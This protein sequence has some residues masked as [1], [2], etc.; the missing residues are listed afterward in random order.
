MFIGR[1]DDAIAIIERSMMIDPLCSI[2]LYFASRLYMFAGELEE[3]VALRQRFIS[4]HGQGHFQYGL[5][6]LL[7]GKPA[8]AATVFRDFEELMAERG[9]ADRGEARVGLAMAFHDLGRA[10]ESDE[11]L[12]AYIDDFGEQN[13]RDVAKIYAWRGEKD[14]AFEWLSRADETGS[15]GDRSFIVDPVFTNLHDDPRWTAMLEARGF[16]E[17]QLAALVFPVELFTEYR[18]E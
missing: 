3:A 18:G 6:K 7:Q 9:G 14:L 11:L 10:G 4:L 16:S 5:M 1:K 8:E 13:P 15:D 17:T 2:C 12:Q